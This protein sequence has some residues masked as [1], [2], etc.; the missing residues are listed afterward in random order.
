MWPS[1]HS[2]AGRSDVPAAR[3]HLRS[4][5]TAGSAG[6]LQVLDL[7][8]N[9]TYLRALRLHIQ[10]EGPPVDTSTCPHTCSIRGRAAQRETSHSSNLRMKDRRTHLQLH[11]VKMPLACEHC[12][13]H[14]EKHETDTPVALV[15]A[16]Q[17]QNECQE[18]SADPQH[19]GGYVG[20]GGALRG[21][22]ARQGRSRRLRLSNG[23]ESFA[24]AHGDVSTCDKDTRTDGEPMS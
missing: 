9:Q 7:A 15:C 21:H 20:A 5:L 8:Q 24:C 1:G 12:N 13:D 14:A 11:C 3:V 16:L 6:L 22:S 2:P 10:S 23:E 19:H 18:T 4:H 17:L